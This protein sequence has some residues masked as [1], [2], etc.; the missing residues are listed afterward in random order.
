MAELQR[1]QVNRKWLAKMVVFLVVLVGFGSWGL[2]DALV[3]YPKRGLDDAAYKQWKYLETAE[4]AG[5]LGTASIGDPAQHHEDLSD[6]RDDLRKGVK[7]ALDLEAI[8]SQNSA[9]GQQAA[10]ELRQHQGD[11]VDYAALEWLDSL[12]LVGRLKAEETTLS[13]PAAKLK[14]LGTKWKSKDPP[15]ALAVYDIPLQWVFTVLGYG[16]GLYLLGLLAKVKA[17]SYAWDAS[18]QT[19]H[20]PGGA[21]ITPADIKEFDKRK[22]DKFF[23]TLHLKDQRPSLKLDLLRWVPLEDWIIAM[24]ATAFPPAAAPTPTPGEAPADAPPAAPV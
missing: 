22:W 7:A 18:T 12:R 1:T 8:A 21:T 20:L 2:A 19:L 10:R 15:K 4:R 3:I 5:R 11:L 6:R 23:V 14:E 17:T 16:G 13:D 9:Q 24:E